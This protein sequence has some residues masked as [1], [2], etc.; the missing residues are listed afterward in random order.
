MH[1]KRLTIL[2]VVLM[3]ALYAQAQWTSVHAT[4]TRMETIT[5][6]DGQVHTN[7]T[8]SEYF[9]SNDGSVLTVTTLRGP[10]GSLQGKTARLY[11]AEEPALY[12]LNYQTKTALLI[13][14]MQAPR[15]LV[16][17][18][19]TLYPNLQHSKYLGINCVRVPVMLDGRRIGTYWVDD[20]DDLTLKKDITLPGSHTVTTLSNITMGQKY[21]PSMFQVPRGFAIDASRSKSIPA[22]E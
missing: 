22:T 12:T 14:R 10:D 11:D 4:E 2:L 20:K 13:V 5:T 21:N 3:P 9:R 18:R 1:T 8:I 19:S 6:P 17:N 16:T 15:P 7:A